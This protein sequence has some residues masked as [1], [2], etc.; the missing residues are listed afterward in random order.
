MQIDLT[1]LKIQD[2]YLLSSLSSTVFA[3][4]SLLIIYLIFY[5]QLPSKLP[6]FYSRPWGQPE[7]VLKSQFLLLPL[8]LA[9]VGL[10]N[11]VV[12]LHLHPFQIV[13]K[14]IIYIGSTLVN[15]AILITAIKIFFIFI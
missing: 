12:A 15:L 4:C 11:H 2:R 5:N 10:V 13:L 8:S 6:L 9:L 14:R 1:K 3:I 7:L